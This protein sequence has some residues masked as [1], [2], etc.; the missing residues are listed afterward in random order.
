MCRRGGS[1]P[2]ACSRASCC[3]ARPG[4]A[5]GSQQVIHP[6]RSAVAVVASARTRRLPIHS[7]AGRLRLSRRRSASHQP[8]T[9]SVAIALLVQ[10][11][12]LGH[13]Q[14]RT[15]SVAGRLG[16]Q[17]SGRRQRLGRPVLLA[18]LKRVHLAVAPPTQRARQLRHLAVGTRHLRS[19]NRL[20][21]VLVRRR[22][23]LERLPPRPA[24]PSVAAVLQLP[25]SAVEAVVPR[26]VGVEEASALR[27]A[28]EV[29]GL[30]LQTQLPRTR[31]ALQARMLQPVSGLREDSAQDSRRPVE[32][33]SV[34]GQQRQ[35]RRHQQHRPSVV[36]PVG[37]A[38]RRH[39]QS[40]P[41]VPLARRPTRRLRLVGLG[42]HASPLRQFLHQTR[43]RT[44]LRRRQTRLRTPRQLKRPAFATML[45]TRS[46]SSSRSSASGWSPLCHHR[47]S[48]AGDITRNE[49]QST[50]D[51]R[52]ADAF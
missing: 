38:C 10:V 1:R 14:Q 26:S 7:E 32:R 34:A 5:L 47:Q 27:S 3:R 51:R 41:G 23:L 20:S 2:S 48:S 6:V 24:R 44:R 15:R 11:Q 45:G 13:Q 52:A 12:A 50:I 17:R 35:V 36:D 25:R 40:L 30:R 29:E 19:A 22:L 33:H 43:L 31:L 42:D 49:S 37:L 28:T 21:L 18:A 16:R 9:P 8:P 46:S 39:L 4:R